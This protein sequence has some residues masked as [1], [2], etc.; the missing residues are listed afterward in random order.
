MCRAQ[1]LVDAELSKVIMARV[2]PGNGDPAIISVGADSSSGSAGGLVQPA[3]PAQP[4]AAAQERRHGTRTR[5]GRR[6]GVR[7]YLPKAPLHAQSVC[8]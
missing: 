5:I 2:H 6:G 4:P 3:L 1:Q 8:W 7:D